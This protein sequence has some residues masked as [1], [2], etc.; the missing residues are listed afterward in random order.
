MRGTGCGVPKS[1]IFLDDRTFLYRTLTQTR[2]AIA[3]W[4]QL[5]EA[6]NLNETIQK[7]KAARNCP[8]FSPFVVSSARILGIDFCFHRLSA[9]RPTQKMHR[10]SGQQRAERLLCIP[11]TRTWFTQKVFCLVTSVSSWG[12]WLQQPEE[13]FFLAQCGQPVAVACR[14]H[15]QQLY[16]W[17]AF[18]SAMPFVQ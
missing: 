11:T 4:W 14:F 15:G 17:L 12:L 1:I 10:Q 18:G 2:Q 9:E 7:T 16:L 3:Q 13:R 5:A 8:D 6:V